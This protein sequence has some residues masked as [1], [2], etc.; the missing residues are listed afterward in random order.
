M[1]VRFFG[2]G[3]RIPNPAPHYSFPKLSRERTNQIPLPNYIV[4][5]CKSFHL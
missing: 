2:N 4:T 1:Q 3:T 5:V